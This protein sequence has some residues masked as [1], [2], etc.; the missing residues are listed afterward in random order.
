[1]KK[2]RAFE[3]YIQITRLLEAMFKYELNVKILFSLSPPAKNIRCQPSTKSALDFEY[4][5]SV[6]LGLVN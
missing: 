2:R 1:M 3:C 5:I 4:D 6:S